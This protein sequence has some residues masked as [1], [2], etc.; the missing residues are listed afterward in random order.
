MVVCKSIAAR[1]GDQNWAYL[2][3]QSL[4]G[5]NGFMYNHYGLLQGKAKEIAGEIPSEK[6]LN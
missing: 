4:A 6:K 2:N 3:L 1:Y 5:R